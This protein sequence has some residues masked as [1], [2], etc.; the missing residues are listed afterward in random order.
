MSLALRRLIPASMSVLFAA[1][2][3]VSMPVSVAATDLSITSGE[4]EV[5]RLLNAERARAGLVPV[6]M[7][8]RLMAIARARSTDMATKHY[9]RH[10][11]PDGRTIFDLLREAG[12][13]R[14]AAGEIIGRNTA[15]TIGESAAVA[16]A[17]WMG[18]PVNRAMATSND[19]N[20]VGVGL[21]IEAGTGK[22]LWTAVFLRG[23]DRT[24]GYAR[25]AAH[26]TRS[27]SSNYRYASVAWNGTDVR[28]VVLTSGL[29]HYQTQIRRDG[30]LWQWR[31]KATR[32]E[33]TTF[34]AWKG[35]T[36][37]YRVRACDNAGN[38]G[39][40]ATATV[41]GPSPTA[42]PTP[43]PDSGDLPGWKLAFS[44]D[45]NQA[46]AAGRFPSDVSSRWSAYPYGWKDTSGNG[47]YDPSIVSVH[48][49]MLDAHIRTTNGVRRVAAFTPKFANGSV[50]QLYG[51]YAVRFR[52]DSMRGY[53]GAW[54]LWPQSEV[55]P[56]DGEIDFPEGDFDSTISAFMHRQDGTW[57]GDQDAFDTTARWTDWHTAVTEW[58]PTAVRFYLDGVL[59]GTS[60][61]RIPN[62][63]MRWVIQNETTLD[64]I[65]PA[66]SV[67]G[68]VLID[69]V[70]VWSYAP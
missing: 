11:Q 30:G 16:V 49:G 2:A 46:V 47:T 21:A 50:N 67:S 39:S 45:F 13:T 10:T 15:S 68:H 35:H 57:G 4:Q 58:T 27:S 38:C 64:G 20:Y 22:K 41:A 48:D 24:G 59:I 28:L 12:I 60:T 23:P 19:F 26:T 69:W 65:V 37:A 40:W 33:S 62:T 1:A 56:R 5:V 7:D 44:D 6:R 61:S 17:S 14:Y 3:V 36:Y 42:T 51:R 32:Y 29:R 31:S 18:T 55:H 53:K 34:Y 52:A 70:K 9:F 43:T 63:P 54:L 8:G 66:D 25:V